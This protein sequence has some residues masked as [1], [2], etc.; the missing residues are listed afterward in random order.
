MD[1]LR[2]TLLSILLL[3]ALVPAAAIA[4][5]DI[6]SADAKTLAESMRGIGLV[7]AEAI[8]AYR[9]THGPFRT[10]DDLSKVKGIGRKTIDA[11]R[12]ELVALT[13]RSGQAGG[14]AGIPGAMLTD[15]TCS[16]AAR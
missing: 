7:K 12:D 1:R 9:S 16:R 14:G 8:V 11:N 4:Q 2:R 10:I 13:P 3:L 5:V 6:N 15:K